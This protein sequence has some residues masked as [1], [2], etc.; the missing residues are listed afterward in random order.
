MKC[1]LCKKEITAKAITLTKAGT[2]AQTVIC[3]DCIT[4]LYFQI[5]PKAKDKTTNKKEQLQKKILNSIK[6]RIKEYYKEFLGTIT[7]YMSD[8]I[9]DDDE[10]YPAEHPIPAN[11]AFEALDETIANHEDTEDDPILNKS[12]KAF[13]V[14]V[15]Q[16][17]HILYDNCNYADI[18]HNIFKDEINNIANHLINAFLEDLDST[19]KN[20]HEEMEKEEEEKKSIDFKI[21][22]P[23]YIKKEL[24]KYVIGQEQAKK[25]VSVGIYNHYKRIETGNTNIKKSNIMLI[26]AS[27]C[28]KTE[29]ARTVAKIVGVPFCIVDATSI[30]EAGY[31]GDDAENMLLKLIQAA[32][33][34]VSKAEKGIIY[35]DEIDKI[36]R[37]GE[38]RSHG[39]DVGG[40]GVQQALLKIVEGSEITISVKSKHN[41][42]G[43]NITINTENIL[44]ICGGAFEELTMTEKIKKSGLGFNSAPIEDET[45]KIDSKAIIKYG[46]IPELM[47][48]FPIVAKLSALEIDD[49]K[50]IL[51]EPENSV[52]QQYTD[53]IKID[54][55]DIKFTDSALKWIATKSYE[56]KTGARGLKTI[57]EDNMLDLMY[58]LP[59]EKDTY[60]VQVG[61]K[62]GKLEIRREKRKKA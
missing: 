48:R 16:A 55:I 33:G 29:I 32:D 45:D 57:L 19:N 14:L 58:D 15:R 42:F 18:P 17:I 31:V 52:I 30:T 40:E 12:L 50:R 28:G 25:I 4:K 60:K 51:V 62:D 43:D 47:G 41:P 6:N 5:N 44:F 21:N 8:A 22:T 61:V 10:M 37:C 53:L 3:N 59:D 54:N 20:L 27:G 11:W 34:D 26:G 23:K 46:I 13:D 56:N 36:A 49:L 24:D 35:I 9:K 7:M 39:R 2:H 38:G 1:S